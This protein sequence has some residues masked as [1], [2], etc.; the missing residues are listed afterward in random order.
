MNP[1]KATTIASRLDVKSARRAGYSPIQVLADQLLFR[2][3]AQLAN[4]LMPEP[5]LG[6][7]GHQLV[8]APYISR[9][10][11]EVVSGEEAGENS[12]QW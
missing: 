8:T 2:V 12:L 7:L 10:W 11:D 3:L 5:A 4:Q 6:Y 9:E 1:Q